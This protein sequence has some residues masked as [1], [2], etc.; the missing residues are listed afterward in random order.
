MKA[1]AKKMSFL[2]TAENSGM[3]GADVTWLAK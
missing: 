3:D 1:T 2:A